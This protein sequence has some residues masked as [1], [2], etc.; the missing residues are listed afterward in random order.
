MNAR[1]FQDAVIK[2][3][4]LQK[5]YDQGV[6]GLQEMKNRLYAKFGVASIREARQ[7]LQNL[8]QQQTAAADVDKIAGQLYQ[9][10]RE[11][12]RIELHA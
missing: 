6:G 5:A 1:E 7:L 12:Q 11:R 3:K 8:E 10:L 4:R 2:L 9:R